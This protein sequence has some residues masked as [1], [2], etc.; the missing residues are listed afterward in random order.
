MADQNRLSPLMPT[1]PPLERTI[2]QRLLSGG[3]WASA[4]KLLSSATGL[5]VTALLARLLTAKEMG[6][7]F[8]IFSL[9]SVAAVLAQLGLDQ[10]VVRLVAGSMGK[11]LPGRARAA[12]NTVLR[13]G[14]L[15]ALLVGVLALGTGPLLAQ[16]VFHSPLLAS[17]MSLAPLWVVV[18]ALQNLTAETFRSFHD[19][20]LASIFT[21]VASNVICAVLLVAL[22]VWRR[23]SSLTEAV[24]ISIV[25]GT[26]TVIIAGLILLQRIRILSGNEQMSSKQVLIAAFPQLVT[27]LTLFATTQAGLWIMGAFR[28]QEETAIYGA[29]L[30]L[31]V[32]VNM[33]MVIVNSVVSPMI[34][35]MYAQKKKKELEA[36][37]QTTATLAGIPAFTALGAFLLLGRLILGMVY[38]KYYA[39][40][41]TVLAVLSTGQLINVWSGS[42]GLTLIMSGHQRTMMKITV[43][44]GILNAAGAMWLVSGYGGT[45]VAAATASATILQNLLMLLLAK[46]KTGVWTHARFSILTSRQIF[47]R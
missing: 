38:G 2:R 32:L 8:L 11:G 21:R 39:G 33:P 24:I 16:H 14:A 12:V 45:G 22:W 13:C 31:V 41:A 26:A 17:V 1:V 35:E 3:A 25:A 37:L 40:G 29:A 28:P 44:C 30:R 18:A 19:I 36:T 20:R 23:D 9:V 27:N 43:V 34:A 47:A 7:Y 5:L 46:R 42:C 6:A 15:G 4:G 10:S